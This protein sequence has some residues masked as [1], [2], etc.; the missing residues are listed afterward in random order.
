MCASWISPTLGFTYTTLSPHLVVT[1][2]Y[3]ALG[4][5]E[6]NTIPDEEEC[7]NLLVF[8]YGVLP[9]LVREGK[10]K[11]NVITEWG[12]GLEK[13]PDEVEHLA[14]GRP[15]ATWQITY[16]HL[17]TFLNLFSLFSKL[18]GLYFVQTYI[19]Q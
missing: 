1:L 4:V 18:I 5:R 13:V 11:P 8:V 10:I 12:G 2:L 14:A 16:S 15:S 6:A 3:T 17:F 19:D 7:K 9:G